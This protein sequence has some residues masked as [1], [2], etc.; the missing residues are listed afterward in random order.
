MSDADKEADDVEG[1][2]DIDENAHVLDG[3][4]E[5]EDEADGEG[6]MSTPTRM[7]LPLPLLLPM[8]RTGTPVSSVPLHSDAPQ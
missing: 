5:D 4:D 3:D 6:E 8:L 7:P 1:E 2:D